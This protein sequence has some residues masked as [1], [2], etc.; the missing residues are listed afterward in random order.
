MVSLISKVK[1]VLS[2]SMYASQERGRLWHDSV[3]PS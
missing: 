3:P 1:D 2:N